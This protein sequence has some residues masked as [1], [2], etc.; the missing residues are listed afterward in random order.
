MADQE[1]RILS[2]QLDTLIRLVAVGLGQGKTLSEQV[3][4]L[5]CAGMAPKDIAE[6]VGSSPNTV[7]VLLYKQKKRTSKGR[8]R[9]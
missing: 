6:V 1:S 2:R 3:R 7:S 9:S 5:S 8:G 4:I